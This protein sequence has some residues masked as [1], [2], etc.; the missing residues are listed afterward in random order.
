[1]TR[2]PRA[3]RREPTPPRSRFRPMLRPQL[4]RLMPPRFRPAVADADGAHAVTHRRL[5]SAL[6]AP[7]RPSSSRPSSFGRRLDCLARL[8]ATTTSHSILPPASVTAAAGCRDDFDSRLL[9]DEAPATHGIIAIRAV[10]RRPGFRAISATQS[11]RH[12]RRVQASRML[13]YVGIIVTFGRW[14][15]DRRRLPGEFSADE[16]ASSQPFE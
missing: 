1:M 9:G 16:M 3:S 13:H 11:S 4:R 7:P 10:P 2:P 8:T 15:I 5:A 14:R 12:V 6:T